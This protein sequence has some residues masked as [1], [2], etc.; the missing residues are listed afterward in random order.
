VLLS[1]YHGGLKE[2]REWLDAPVLVIVRLAGC[3]KRRNSTKKESRNDNVKP[4]Q[5]LLDVAEQFLLKMKEEKDGSS[6]TGGSKS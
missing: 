2:A 6:T 5:E 1:Q 3:I 4:T